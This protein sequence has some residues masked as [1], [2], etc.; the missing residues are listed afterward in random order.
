MKKFTMKE[1]SEGMVFEQTVYQ[2]DPFIWQKGSTPFGGVYEFPTGSVFTVTNPPFKKQGVTL[3][4][5]SVKG[6]EGEFE[7]HWKFF[8][9]RTNFL[10]G[11][12][13]EKIGIGITSKGP[14][15]GFDISVGKVRFSEKDFVD[16][17][18][19]AI[20]KIEIVFEGEFEGAK[21]VNTKIINT[22][23]KS[24][25]FKEKCFSLL[26]EVLDQEKEYI[27][28]CIDL[29]NKKDFEVS[30]ESEKNAPINT[31][32]KAGKLEFE[33]IL[34]APL[35]TV[36]KHLEIQ[37]DNFVNSHKTNVYFHERPQMKEK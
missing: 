32:Y 16:F 7:A 15:A 10:S 19:Y 21:K 4:N 36:Y 26:K 37:M 6:T 28:D 18:G 1:I 27:T 29:T 14:F 2:D 31:F 8:K 25:G 13:L 17:M 24:K 22:I 3:I 35:E 20:V 34:T 23:K 12:P 11:E 5:F 33:I 30:S 9:E